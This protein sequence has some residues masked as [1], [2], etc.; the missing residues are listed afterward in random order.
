MTKIACV[1]ATTLG[2]NGILTVTAEGNGGI[3]ATGVSAVVAN[4]TATDTT[5]QSHLTVFPAGQIE[6]NASNL[7]WTAGTTV[8]N[9]V[10]VALSSSG[11][12]ETENL[13]GSVDVIID[14]EG[15]FTA[16]SAGTGL[17]NA[18]ASPARICD[19]RTGNPSS[20]SGTALTQCEGKAPSAGSSIAVTVAGLG[21]VPAT[22]V[23]SVVLNLTAVSP[24]GSGH[25]TAYP[26]GGS[27]NSSNVNYV[28]GQVV[29]NR[30]IVP[31]GT[32]GQVDIYSSGGTPNVLVDVAGW[33][34]DGSNSS[35]TGST[36]TPA[37]SPTRACDTRADL[38]YYTP[39]ADHTLGANGTLPVLLPGPMPSHRESQP[40]SST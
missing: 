11:T 21:G 38:V 4:V 28:A 20:L 27:Q 40:W 13:S 35:A 36:F 16:G 23:G 19:T 14:V 26:A 37:I 5:A 22:G 2:P 29:P 12:F 24:T 39:C 25:L 32:D 9:L 34:T 33:F 3:P 7:N 15:Y 8:P 31:L 6:P 1:G 30:V 17:Y 18:L 10:T